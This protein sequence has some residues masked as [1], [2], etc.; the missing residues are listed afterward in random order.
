M[1]LL[2]V[3]LAACESRPDPSSTPAAEPQATELRA[4]STEPFPGTSWRRDGERIPSNVIALTS[5]S[6]HCGHR[7]VLL[8]T[9]GRP[10]GRTF[11]T[12]VEAQ[13]FVRDPSNTFH[14]TTLAPF[15]PSVTM[16]VDAVFTGYVYGTDQ[17][18]VSPSDADAVF[19]V[20]G[21]AVEL[22]PRARELIACA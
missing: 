6:E 17:L 10:L 11:R 1:M 14:D 15:L 5:L 2:V 22:W 4:P 9:I 21:G 19:V 20:R 12:D 18:W 7:D 16:P 13:Q 8:L 3:G